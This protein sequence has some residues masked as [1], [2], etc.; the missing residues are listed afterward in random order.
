MGACW[1][2]YRAHDINHMSLW[3]KQACRSLL[4]QNTKQL[5][6]LMRTPP[7][8]TTGTCVLIN[9]KKQ[10]VWCFYNLSVSPLR[11]FLRER[12]ACSKSLVSRATQTIVSAWAPAAVARIRARSCADHWAPPPCSRCVARRRRLL[13]SC[14]PWTRA[15]ARGWSPATSASPRS[16]CACSRA[17]PSS[18]PA[19][20]STS[21]WS[22]GILT[23][24]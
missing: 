24:G 7:V 6:S 5:I 21:S 19:C 16:S 23:I 1:E 8:Q 11:R 4:H 20:Y 15:K 17:S 9:E 12:R 18:S 10:T 22:E 14:A 2:L 13:Q 3:P